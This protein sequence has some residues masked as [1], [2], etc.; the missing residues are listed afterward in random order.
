MPEERH[1]GR[2]FL[3]VLVALLAAGCSRDAGDEP[4]VDSARLLTDGRREAVHWIVAGRQEAVSPELAVQLGYLERHRLGLGSP[5]R[6]IE[7]LLNDPRLNESARRRT[8]WALLARTLDGQGYQ[9]DPT[10]LDLVGATGAEWMAGVGRYHLRLIENLISEA[11]D[12]R[13]GELAVRLAYA[14]AAAEGSVSPA[15]PLVVAQTAALAR[16]RELARRDAKRLVRAAQEEGSDPLDLLVDWRTDR[17]FEVEAPPLTPLPAESE[18]E[19]IEFALRLVR[20]VERLGPR[21]VANGQTTRQMW[22][23]SGSLLGPEAAR[24]LA[25]VA[26]EF[27][28]PPRTPVVAAVRAQGR[29]G[30]TGW[31][32]EGEREAWDRFLTRARDEEGLAAEYALLL[33]SVPDAA[34]AA[35]SVVLSAA[36]G[37]RTYAQE[38]IWFPGFGG[39]SARELE[40]GF[41]LAA[42][43]F[44]PDV[45]AAWRPFYRGVLADALTELQRVLPSLNVRGLAFHFGS[46]RGGEATLALHDP[47]RRTIYLSPETGM[48]TL[49]HEVAHDLDW[50]VALRRFRVR[51]DYASDRVV[52]ERGGPMA[53]ALQRLSTAT[54]R[55]PVPGDPASVIHAQRPAEVFARS[56]DWFVLVSLAREGRSNGYLT[57]AQDGLLTGYGTVRPPDI[58]GDAGQALVAILDEIAPV[59]PE[60]RDWFL[61][62]YGPNRTPT[63]Y[64]LVRRI[65][66]TELEGEGLALEWVAEGAEEV[67][68]EVPHAPPLGI[69]GAV[70]ERFRTLTAVRGAALAMTDARWCRTPGESYDSGLALARRRLVARAAEARGRGVAIHYAGLLAGHEGREWISGSFFRGEDADTGLDSL[71]IAFLDEMA[72]EVRRLGEVRVEGRAGE[73]PGLAAP[74]Y[75]ASLTG[76]GRGGASTCSALLLGGAERSYAGDVGAPDHFVQLDLKAS[77]EPVLQDPVGQVLQIDIVPDW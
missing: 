10:V 37:M 8:A 34:M 16:D 70:R 57:S 20:T 59:Y 50:Q 69:A 17:A 21:L 49:A 24:V 64:D 32:E 38:K 74:G 46:R 22:S 7:F 25:E 75:L 77:R 35:G 3:F 39:P 45:P 2:L 62:S 27:E 47:L 58:G 13:S 44:D 68:A 60:T 6:L 12:P 11:P 31:L 48:G 14:L 63:A 15:A 4:T 52:R 66:E 54:L 76:I 18:R 36:V 40:D 5:F 56:V 9:L 73:W 55:P 61:R 71:S 42:V 33:E 29:D 53:G 67:G 51:G 30:G 28:A 72:A 43:R 65:L 26:E 41:G 19:A 23:G 1:L